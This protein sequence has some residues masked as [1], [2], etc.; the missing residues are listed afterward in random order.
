VVRDVVS[1]LGIIAVQLHRMHRTAEQKPSNK[2]KGVV[3]FWDNIMNI[4]VFK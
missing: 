4:Q 2:M 3:S 1:F